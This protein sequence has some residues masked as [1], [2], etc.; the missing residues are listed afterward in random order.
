SP[1]SFQGVGNDGLRWMRE[2]A[3]AHHLKVVTEAMGSE[4][5]EVVAR[6][7]DMIQIG[8]RNMQNFALLHAVGRAGLPVLLK[9]GLS[10]T[11]E[12]WL[13]AAEHTLQAGASAVLFCERGVRAFDN[14]TRFLMD[15]SAIALLRDVY[16]VPIIADPS[17]AAGRKDIIVRLGLASLAAGAHGLIIE[18]HPD[19]AVACSDGPQ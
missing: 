1:Y 11:I 6:H 10:A 13:L 19:P 15:L 12:E 4:Q 3:D 8:A 9:R 2:A 5:V 17:H 16:Q 18:T 7:A 14:T